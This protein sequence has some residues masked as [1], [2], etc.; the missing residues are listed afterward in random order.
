MT[1]PKSSD[2]FDESRFSDNPSFHYTERNATSSQNKEEEEEE[3]GGR[4]NGL[5]HYVVDI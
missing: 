5:H 4:V 2:A 3:D 1:L